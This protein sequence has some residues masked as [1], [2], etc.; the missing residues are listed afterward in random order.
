MTAVDSATEAARK[1]NEREYHNKAFAE[2]TRSPV[3]K[4][5]SVVRASRD[6]FN[7]RIEALAPGADA[8]E[9]GCGPGSSSFR[10]AEAGARVTG[11]DISDVA[12]AQCAE[13]ARSEG[14]P[15]KF[16]VMDAEKLTFPD[17]SF[18]L[19]CG[20]GIL[21]HL[22][23]ERAFT[24]ISRTLRPEGTAYFIEPMGHNPAINL[25]RR[26]TP[27]LRTVDEHPFVMR[28][29]DVARR[30]FGKVELK[31]FH[32]ASLACFPFERAPG[33]GTF[34]TAFD[35]IDRGLFATLPFLRRYAWVVVISLREPV[36]ARS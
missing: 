18:D 19:I 12:I 14:V 31:F 7:R 10:L 25:Y 29:F 34:L 32:L 4:F 3:A 26:F 35:G 17:S 36:K 11:I 8:L 6:D 21:H 9:Y 30:H 5:Y 20:T 13:R 2:A 22:D 1:Q 23:L 33:F 27:Q 24:Q 28:D 16:Q 15:A